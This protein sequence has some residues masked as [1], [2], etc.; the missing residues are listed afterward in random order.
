LQAYPTYSSSLQLMAGSQA[1]ES[2]QHGPAR[3]AMNL[4]RR[5]TLKGL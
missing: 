1:L 3:M 4:L 2:L 5:L